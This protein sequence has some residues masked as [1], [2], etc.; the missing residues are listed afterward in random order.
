MKIKYAIIENE[1]FAL[2]LLKNIISQ[3]CP[4]YDLMFTAESVEE[5]VA[6][7][8]QE[9]DIQLIFMDIELV[10][11]SCFEI[12]RQVPIDIP[13]IFTTAYNE[14]AIQA[15]EVN[16]LDYILKPVTEEAMEH[17]LRKF[18]KY[19]ILPI[20]VSVF[21]KLK[22]ILSEK[23]KRKKRILANLGNNYSYIDIDDVAY[24]ISEDKYIFLIS[25][26]GKRSLTTYTNLNQVEEDVESELFIRI[27][28]NVVVNIKAILKI[29][30][31]YNG[32]LLVKIKNSEES[33]IISAA[34]REHFLNWLGD[35]ID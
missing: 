29:E 25:F 8:K 24:F 9:T 28:R 22:D 2:A 27:A 17:A 6:F 34:R 16:S 32:R 35:E 18:E 19:N 4:D 1:Y 11:G 12:F 7:F 30:K 5:S 23:K 31:Y 3:L 13:V 21:E 15:F 14:F 26:S 33:F 10:D 20:Q